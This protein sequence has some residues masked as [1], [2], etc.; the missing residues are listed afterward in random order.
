MANRGPNT[1]GSQFFITT[2]PAPHLDGMHVIFGQVVAGKDVVKE[3]ED[4]DTD[5][6]DRPLQDARMINCGELIKRVKKKRA[7]S[8]S[9]SASS[10]ESVSSS[11]SSEEE[12]K[13]KKKKKKKDKKKKAKK[14]KKKA[15]K[16]E[17]EA[18]DGEIDEPHP[19]VSLSKIDPDEIP[20]VP[21]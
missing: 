4:L 6:K 12:K 21:R 3:L 7:R 15:K 11:S 1:N 9:E 8:S 13:R 14:S 17:S 20:D 19:L 16:S 10:S 2:A 5:K 18:E